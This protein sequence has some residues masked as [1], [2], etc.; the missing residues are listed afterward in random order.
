[1]SSF[2]SKVLSRNGPSIRGRPRTFAGITLLFMLNSKLKV[3]DTLMPQP[4][5]N[6]GNI[7]HSPFF[8]DHHSDHSHHRYAKQIL[9]FYN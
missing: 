1:M 9:Y 2:N 5:T 8:Q 6:L 7:L 3:H 4:N